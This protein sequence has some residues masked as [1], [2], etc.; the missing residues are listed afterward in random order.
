MRYVCHGIA[1]GIEPHSMIHFSAAKV[2][3]KCP[4]LHLFWQDSRFFR[5]TPPTGETA[6][7]VRPPSVARVVLDGRS[8]CLVT[9]WRRFWLFLV[10]GL[11]YSLPMFL[12]DLCKM[13]TRPLFLKGIRFTISLENRP[14][15][16]LVKDLR[17]AREE[18]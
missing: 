6:A 4:S 15:S 5:T 8:G 11:C 7:A 16:R 3:H 10:V 17:F 9:G 18:S 1:V 14:N 2:Q 12:L 13:D